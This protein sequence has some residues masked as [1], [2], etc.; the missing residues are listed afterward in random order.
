LFSRDL[1][2]SQERSFAKGAP[3]F[4]EHVCI[5]TFVWECRL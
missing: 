1:E 5:H 4:R 2:G 3:R